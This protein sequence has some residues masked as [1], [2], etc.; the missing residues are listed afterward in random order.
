MTHNYNGGGCTHD[1]HVRARSSDAGVRGTLRATPP[2]CGR[3]FLRVIEIVILTKF[4]LQLIRLIELG[5]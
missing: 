3:S 4:W 2:T 5:V 1:V